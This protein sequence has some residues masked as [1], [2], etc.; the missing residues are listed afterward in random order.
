MMWKIVSSGGLEH[1]WLIQNI[2]DR[3]EEEEEEE[4]DYLKYTFTICNKLYNE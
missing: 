3:G 2:W 4:E 1:R